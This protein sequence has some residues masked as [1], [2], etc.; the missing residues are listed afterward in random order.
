MSE[1]IHRVA[2][3]LPMPSS[4]RGTTLIIALIVLVAMTLA[5]IATMRSVDTATLM[6]GNIAFRQSALHAA[7]Q[8][9]QAGYALLI[10][11]WTNVSADLNKD[12]LGLGKPG[13]YSS[14]SM[15]EPNW[16]DP[17]AWNNAAQLAPDAAGNVVWFLVER[18]CT[19]AN[20]KPGDTCTGS[21]NL[22]GSTPGTATTS[23]GREGDDNFRPAEAFS[24][25]APHYRITARAVGPRNSIA[26]VQTLTR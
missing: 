6:A 18:M 21:N 23:S 4:Q 7:D 13:Y 17:N 2:R 14:A 11:P 24:S 26:I 20:C 1:Q 9:I 19:V 16:S 12:G 10:T 25:P 5:G 3:R 8:G 15:T 22:C